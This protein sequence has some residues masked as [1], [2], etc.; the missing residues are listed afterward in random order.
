MNFYFDLFTCIY[1]ANDWQLTYDMIF[2]S[3][4]S[5]WLRSFLY[6]FMSD[7]FAPIGV[8]FWYCIFTWHLLEIEDVTNYAANLDAVDLDGI[9]FMTPV[10]CGVKHN[11]KFDMC[12]FPSEETI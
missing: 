2:K 9:L 7:L 3:L 6:N 11:P 4:E 5:F 8:H 10:S 12:S 1:S